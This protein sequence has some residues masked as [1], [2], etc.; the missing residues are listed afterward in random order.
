MKRKTII[1]IGIGVMLA[2]ASLLISACYHHSPEGKIA[3][4]K[5][6]ITDRLSLDAAQQAMLD[7]IAA[8]VLDRGQQMHQGR[9]AMHATLLAELSKEHMDR[10]TIETMVAQKRQQ[11]QDMTE[12]LIDS[13]IALHE[14][15][16]PQ[17]REKLVAGLEK[18]RA[19]AEKYHGRW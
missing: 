6:E 10:A 4:I 1:G 2:S 18:F 8:G 15:L 11:M 5:D 19:R 7:Q 9:E 12:Y 3:W 14:T 17:Q 13:A 16:T